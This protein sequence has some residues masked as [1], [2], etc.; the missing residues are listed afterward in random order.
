MALLSNSVYFYAAKATQAVLKSSTKGR[1]LLRQ[2]YLSEPSAG[3]L[4]MQFHFCF[5]ELV[6]DAS[7]DR[8]CFR[9]SNLMRDLFCERH[10]DQLTTFFEVAKCATRHTQFTSH[11][12]L[13][14]I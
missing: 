5:V 3:Q 10:T 7:L 2:S 13:R 4:K 9:K 12:H 8:Q 11:F 1:Q 6:L 14:Q